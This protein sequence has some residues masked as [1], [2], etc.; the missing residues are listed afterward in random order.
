MKT[1]LGFKN[2]LLKTDSS[3]TELIR[4]QDIVIDFQDSCYLLK[5]N[6]KGGKSR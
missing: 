1:R 4:I 5:K 3:Q 2:N 6:V